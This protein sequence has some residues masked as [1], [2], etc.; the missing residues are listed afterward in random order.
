M[1]K[2]LFLSANPFDTEPLRLD[3]EMRAI[4]LA[5]RQAKFCSQLPPPEAVVVDCVEWS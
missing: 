2:I 5:L 4:D 3:E 1:I